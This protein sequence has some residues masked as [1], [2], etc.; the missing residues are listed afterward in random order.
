[1]HLRPEF[2]PP[3]GLTRPPTGRLL[4]SSDHSSVSSTEEGGTGSRAPH[5]SV[6]SRF[7]L[8]SVTSEVLRSPDLVLDSYSH[9]PFTNPYLPPHSNTLSP[10]SKTPPSHQKALPTTSTPPLDSGTP[11]M[12][13]KLQGLGDDDFGASLMAELSSFGSLLDTF[14]TSGK[15]SFSSSVSKPPSSSSTV[16]TTVSSSSFNNPTGE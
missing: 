14:G 8:S 16:S 5:H 13:S 1:M 15:T 12:N 3:G 10:L 4:T 2:Y 7:S 9:T 6:E 11:T